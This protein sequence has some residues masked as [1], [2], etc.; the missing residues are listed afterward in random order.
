M[1]K[2]E[3]YRIRE[4][5][6]RLEKELRAKRQWAQPPSERPS[7]SKW[8]SSEASDMARE[9]EDFRLRGRSRLP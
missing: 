7:H 5:Q 2:D 9:V 6:L 4:E 1:L 3:N 8:R